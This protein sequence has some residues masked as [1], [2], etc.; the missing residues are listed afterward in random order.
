M[1]TILVQSGDKGIR[2][3]L[4][5]AMRAS[6]KSRLTVAEELSKRID[7]TI[8]V[9]TLNKWASEGESA[10]RLP[11]DCVLPLSEILADDSLQRLMLGEHMARCLRLG[12]W[13]LSSRWIIEELDIELPRGCALGELKRSLDPP[14]RKMAREG[15][16]NA[17]RLKRA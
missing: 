1:D 13:L 9:E 8:S 4:R 6:P 10:R 14:T 2:E 12:E 7:R 3:S 11:A 15:K 17:A 16:D 5:R